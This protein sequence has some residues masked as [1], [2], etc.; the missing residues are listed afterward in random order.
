MK[1]EQSDA[2]KCVLLLKAIVVRWPKTEREEEAGPAFVE[3]RARE[4][5]R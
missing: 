4:R 2:S 3:R 1:Q 5:L